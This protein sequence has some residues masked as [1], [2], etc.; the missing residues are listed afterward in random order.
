[1]KILAYTENYASP[2]ITFI[3]NELGKVDQLHE[4]VLVYSKGSNLERYPLTR[5][6]EIPYQFNRFFNKLR[7]W[8]EQSETFYWLR[9]T[10]FKRKVNKLVDSFDPDVIHCHFGIDFLKLFE[11]LNEENRRRPILVSFYG[12]D[13]TERIAN[14]AVLKCYQKALSN[15]NVHPVAVSKNLVDNINEQINPRNKAK[16]LHSGI[17]VNFFKRKEVVQKNEFTFLQVSSFNTKKGHYYTLQAFKKFIE[18][19]PDRKVRFVIA[20]FGPLEESIR[21]QITELQL[22]EVVDLRGPVTPKEMIELSSEADCFVHMSITAKNGDQEGL[23]NVLLEAMALELPILSTNHAGIPEIVENGVN[24][25]L[26]RERN[27]DDYVKGFQLMLEWK[28][29]SANR[30]KIIDEFS[31]ESHIMK[32]NTEY[33]NCI[34]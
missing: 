22:G 14:R 1:M 30:K 20:G 31:M 32:L 10:K 15:A 11:N 4:L 8:L 13:V 18:L 23:P 34:K 16:V 21:N 3:T 9:N 17:D 2:T 6:E 28:L 7:W 25:I 24:G 5:I 29:Q 12:Y 33:A 19:K 26:C 27:M